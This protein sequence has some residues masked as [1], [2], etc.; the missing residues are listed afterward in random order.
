LKYNSKLANKIPKDV[1]DA[2]EKAKKDIVSGSLKV[3]LPQKKQ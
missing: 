1:M 2:V 3:T